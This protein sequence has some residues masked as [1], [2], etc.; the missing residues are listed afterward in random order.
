MP[1][2]DHLWG[3]RDWYKTPYYLDSPAHFASETGWHGCPNLDS[4]CRMMTPG[5]VYPWRGGG[6][7]VPSA[8]F[9]WNDEWRLKASNPF[10]DP[11]S[12]LWR[13]NDLMTN[14]A[15]R[16]FGAVQR[17]LGEFV[18]QSQTFQAEALKTMVEVFRARKFTRTGGL[19]WWNVRD[20]W[21][22]L[23]DA[24][25]DWYGGRKAAFFALRDAQRP[26][27]A[28][29]LD[30]HAAWVVNDTLAPVAVRATYRDRASG[31]VL[32]DG[33]WRIAANAAEK[34]G[35]VP[36]E[37][38][39]VIDIEYAVNGGA[40]ERNHYLYGEPPFR[41]ADV[42]AWLAET[43]GATTAS[44]VRGVVVRGHGVASGKAGDARFPG[45]TIAM[46][47]PYFK[48]LGLDLAGYHL[49]TI[50]VDC[51]PLRFE[52][53]PDA[54]LFERVKWHPEM[55]AETFSIARAVIV[56]HGVRHPALIYLPHP[57][58]KAEHFQPGGVAEIIATRI[59]GLAY[60]DAVTL[61]TAPGQAR[62]V[63]L[64]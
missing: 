33:E 18:A 48:A 25:V 7:G 17:D 14:Q 3:A 22:Q 49:G 62:W 56:H 21:P 34:I 28:L 45:G 36:F 55:P 52:P 23:S 50:N 16:M 39:G 44:V 51:T 19:V 15:H 30:D 2:E 8:T 26:V 6:T 37:G 63:P 31:A 46:Q 61:E 47:A 64:P 53:G 57:E 40:P 54:Y 4:L 41:W 32:L 29:L 59:D 1:S 60:G 58:T 9:D 24:V 42:R 38:Q 12:G 5:C 27:L 13:R 43:A 11:D 10:L 35:E 20:G